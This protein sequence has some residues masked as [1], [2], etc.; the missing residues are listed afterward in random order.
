MEVLE[1]HLE[2]VSTT[3]YLIDFHS[4]CW[5]VIYN[6]KGTIAVTVMENKKRV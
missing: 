6:L 5:I 3:Y 4:K 2:G 1:D